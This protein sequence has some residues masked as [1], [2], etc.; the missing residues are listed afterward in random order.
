MQITCADYPCKH[1][2]HR[3]TN[4]FDDCC[5]ITDTPTPDDIET[6]GCKP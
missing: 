1:D 6:I 5:D 4:V 3:C 2:A